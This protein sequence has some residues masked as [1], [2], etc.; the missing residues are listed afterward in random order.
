MKIKNL[1][2]FKELS[3]SQQCSHFGVQTYVF[4]SGIFGSKC[5]T[6]FSGGGSQMGHTS[7]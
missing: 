3:S 4:N 5:P 6:Y 1:I 7:K 2:R